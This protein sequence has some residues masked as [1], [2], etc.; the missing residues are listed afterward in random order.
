MERVQEDHR[1]HVRHDGHRDVPLEFLKDR[2]DLRIRLH[3]AVLVERFV[4]A[5]VHVTSDSESGEPFVEGPSVRF[6]ECHERIRGVLG[7]EALPPEIVGD[8][9][10]RL[11]MFREEPHEDLGHRVGAALEQRAKCV[12]TQAAIP[13]EVL[14]RD[15]EARPAAR[16]SHE[17]PREHRR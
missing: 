10:D 13:S 17:S 8:P 5:G 1:V 15:D 14:R 11:A 4:D 6:P 16:R 12:E 9:I 2:V 3:M 7:V